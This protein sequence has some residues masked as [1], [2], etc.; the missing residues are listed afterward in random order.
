MFVLLPILSFVVRKFLYLIPNLQAF[1]F[2]IR[3]VYMCSFFKVMIE[4]IDYDR[5]I[6]QGCLVLYFPVFEE[7]SMQ[8]QFEANVIKYVHVNFVDAK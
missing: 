2:L 7:L 8:P 6:V 1:L 3:F 5:Y 4:I